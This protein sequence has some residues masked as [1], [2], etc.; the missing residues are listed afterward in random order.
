MLKQCYGFDSRE[1]RS[2]PKRDT[3]S[4]SSHTN[5]YCE[6]YDYGCW[7]TNPQTLSICVDEIR[8]ILKIAH[9]GSPL[10]VLSCLNIMHSYCHL[11]DN[12][13]LKFLLGNT[14]WIF[15][16][17][18]PIFYPTSYAL[19]IFE[20]ISRRCQFTLYWPRIDV[21]RMAV[22]IWFLR[23]TGTVFLNLCFSQSRKSCLFCF[24]LFSVH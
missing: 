24:R 13:M 2:I 21:I 4:N 22:K 7:L 3:V 18:F 20:G 1:Y 16:H 9:P 12:E 11:P 5:Q 10:M 8:F 23:G 14:Q 15:L 6:S 19:L 17:K